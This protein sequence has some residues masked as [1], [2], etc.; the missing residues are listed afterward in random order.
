M[1]PAV[2]DLLERRGFDGGVIDRW[3]ERGWLEPYKGRGFRAEARIDGAKANVYRF[4][5]AAID[6]AVG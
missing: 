3:H 1:I 6:E 4:A 2:K 5:R